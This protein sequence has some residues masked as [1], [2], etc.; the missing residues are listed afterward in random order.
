MLETIQQLILSELGVEVS[1]LENTTPAGFSV[2]LEKI[3]EVCQLL[4]AHK[5]TYF[6][7]LACLS[8]IDNGTEANS[9][10]VIYTL[11]SIPNDFHLTLKVIL[12][13]ANPVV[14]TV[15]D[16]WRG[17]NWHEREAFDLL[18]IEFANHPDL[19]RILLPADW[20][21]FPMRK[22]YVEDQSYH[23]LTIKHP[24]ADRA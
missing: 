7:H 1:K 21:G 10:E 16:I 4:H 5:S 20:V 18:G 9:M 17:A 2:P 19:R 15:S 8:G 22:D 11:Y 24:D 12:A 23:G 3:H 6:D 13:R 14:D